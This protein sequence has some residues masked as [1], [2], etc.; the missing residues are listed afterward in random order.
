MPNV[1]LS[2]EPETEDAKIEIVAG[3]SAALTGP[4]CLW[5]LFQLE[6]P[7]GLFWFLSIIFFASWTVAG[8]YLLFKHRKKIGKP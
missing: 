8:F 5:F 2:E 6:V 3:F 1:D 7:K 4:L